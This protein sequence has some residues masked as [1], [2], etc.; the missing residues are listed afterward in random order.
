[1]NLVYVNALPT[2]KGEV[3]D[4]SDLD[5]CSIKVKRGPVEYQSE[6]APEAGCALW[7]LTFEKGCDDK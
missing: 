4:D 3:T 5:A 1:M 2:L 7:C 6:N